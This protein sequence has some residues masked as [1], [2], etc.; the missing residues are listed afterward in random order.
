LLAGENV[1]EIVAERPDGARVRREL[2]VTRANAPAFGVSVVQSTG[3]APF[4]VLFEIAQYEEGEV[5]EVAIDQESDGR[6]DVTNVA[7]DRYIGARYEAAGSFVATISLTT[8]TGEVMTFRVPIMVQTAAEIGQQVLQT[9]NVLT[10]ALRTSDL[11]TAL[12][13]LTT[14]AAGRYGPAFEQLGSD[15]PSITDAFGTLSI[16]YTSPEIAE[17]VI[18]R[19]VAGVDRAFIITFL[20]TRDGRWRVASF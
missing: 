7:G 14:T 11:A 16:S 2:R 19:T 20:K 15:L 6:I 5:S 13:L 10:D 18:A 9:W 1:I 17:G 3:V 8:V 12:S 4:D